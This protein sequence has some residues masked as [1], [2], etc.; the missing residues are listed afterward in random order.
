M[1]TLNLFSTHN[2]VSH[3]CLYFFA[4]FRFSKLTA[5][6]KWRRNVSLIRTNLHLFQ[7]DRDL[8]WQ[9]ANS[10][11]KVYLNFGF[12][13]IQKRSSLYFFKRGGS[14]ARV[15]SVGQASGFSGHST[16]VLHA[17][18]MSRVLLCDRVS[19]LLLSFYFTVT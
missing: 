2:I 12:K 1:S 19:I 5:P 16:S 6:K 9:Y 11:H 8:N 14:W 15:C 18:K 7:S 17:V 10:T 4:F 13:S 3:A